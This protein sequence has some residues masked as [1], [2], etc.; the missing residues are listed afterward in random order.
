VCPAACTQISWTTGNSCAENQHRSCSFGPPRSAR[1]LA[2]CSPVNPPSPEP[3][4]KPDLVPPAAAPAPK[5][6]PRFSEIDSLRAVACALVIVGHSVK[7]FGVASAERVGPVNAV[8]G[9]FGILG[10]YLFFIISGFV[11]PQSLRG[12]RGFGLRSFIIRRFWRLFPPFW[13]AGGIAYFSG[14]YNIRGNTLAYGATMC[15]SLFGQPYLLGHF[16]TLEIEVYFYLAV[17]AV[18]LVFGRLGFKTIF[19]IHCLLV[20]LSLVVVDDI[21]GLDFGAKIPFYFSLMFYGACCREI[22]EGRGPFYGR[23][24]CARAIMVGGISGVYCIWPLSVGYLA[25]TAADVRDMQA[26]ALVSASLFIFLFWG[27]LVPI[28]SRFLSSVG[29]WTYSV[30]LL[31]LFPISLVFRG[32]QMGHLKPPETLILS[33]GYVVTML[34]ICFGIGAVAY[35]WI[36][37]PSDR[38]GKRLAG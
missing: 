35:R 3:L 14:A 12:R 36:E 34:F 27:L 32:L 4:P 13:V 10:V 16:W 26:S 17:S 9:G 6:K 5:G 25:W 7:I 38:I 22:M 1:I 15:P 37:Q 19:P 2:N 23:L 8:L 18:F 20:I 31:H 24:K 30:Y 33:I 11:I 21:R 28:R 29:R